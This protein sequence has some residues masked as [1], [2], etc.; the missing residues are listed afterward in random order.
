[1]DSKTINILWSI[2]LMAIGIAAFILAGSN[3]IGI[4][5]PDI[6]IRVLGIIELISLPVLIFSTVKKTNNKK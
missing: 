6:V 1:M 4:E 2:S 5:L 3:I